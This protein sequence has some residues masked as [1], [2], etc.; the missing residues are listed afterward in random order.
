MEKRIF[1][2]NKRN[3]ITVLLIVIGFIMDTGVNITLRYYVLVTESYMNYIYSAIITISF[4]SFSFIA[5]ITG[6]L[7]KKYYGYKLREII[8][9]RE[10]PINPEY[11]K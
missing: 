2:F 10:A 3:V 6:V 7:D 8:Q 1:K 5:I 4:L 9:F 11:W